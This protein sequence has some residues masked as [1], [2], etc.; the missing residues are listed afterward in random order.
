MLCGLQGTLQMKGQAG[1]R[2]VREAHGGL[3]SAAR[4]GMGAADSVGLWGPR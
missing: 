3:T 2:A 1:W 4:V